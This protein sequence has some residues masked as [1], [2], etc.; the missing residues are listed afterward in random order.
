MTAPP[1]VSGESPLK[2]PSDADLLEQISRGNQAAY[3]ELVSRHGRSLY[4]IA[5]SMTGNAADAEDVVQ[6]TMIAAL[7]S[8]FRGE[9]KVRTWLVGI[10]VRRA[11]MLHRTKRRHARTVSL[12]GSDASGNKSSMGQQ[13][14]SVAGR[15]SIGGTEARLD[16]SV[17][18]EKLSPEHREVI[19]LRELEGLTYE[20]IAATLDVPRGT[21]ESRL[22]RAREDLRR[23]FKGYQP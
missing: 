6:E 8:R 16:L 17:M 20:E 23:R 13:I 10:L 4:G 12:S 18:L 19:I 2:I 21:V 9:S 1:G 3:R 11:G 14:E 15:Q 7:N 5:H 22:H